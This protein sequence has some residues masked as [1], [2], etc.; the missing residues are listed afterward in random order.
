MIK[1]HLNKYYLY[2]TFLF[3]AQTFVSCN[4]KRDFIAEEIVAVE[5]QAAKTD[6]LMALTKELNIRGTTARNMADYKEALNLHFRALNLAEATKD[7]MGQIYALNNIGTDLRRTYS[8]IEASTYHYLAL[9][10]STGNSKY[11]KNRAMAMNGLGNIF[12]ALNK[13]EQARSYFQQALAI[14][15]A[16]NS[17]LGQAINYANLAETYH[18]SNDLDSSLYFYEES[19]KQNKIIDSDIGEAICKRAMGLIYYQKGNPD[20]ALSLLNEAF[21][22]MEN[23]K[24][25]FHKLE[26]QITLAETLINLN[27]TKDAEPHVLQILS[28]AKEVNTYD[29]QQKSYKL[30]A[31]LREKQQ[32]YRQAYEAKEMGLVYR[33]SVLAQN[34][35]VRIL[36]LENRYKGK[37]AAQKIQLLTTENILAEK[38]KTEMQRI[39]FLLILLLSIFIGFLY[40]RYNN[41]LKISK[42]LEKVNEIK[43]KFFGNISH[44][45]RTPL[46]LIKG[47]LEKWLERDLPNDLEKDAR[48]ML[49]NSERL[50]FLVDQ[51]LSLSKVDSDNFKINPQHADLSLALRGI[52]NYFLHIANE[53]SINYHIRI[54]S[55]GKEWIDLHIVEIIVTN[56]LSN[57]LKFTEENGTISLIGEKDKD[58][59]RVKVANS[60]KRIDSEE[61]PKIF[62]RFYTHGP[63]HY[64]STGIGLSLVKELCMLYNAKLTVEYNKKDEIEFTIVFPPLP[65]AEASNIE[66]VALENLSV[67]RFQVVRE[68]SVKGTLD[69]AVEQSSDLALTEKPVLLV[70]EDN[71][72]LRDYIVESFKDICDTL[73]AKNGE[74]GI[75]LAQEH[76]PD[77]VITDIMMPKIDGLQLCNTLKTNPTTNHIPIIILTAL[78]E[79]RDLIAGLENKADDYVTKPFGANILKQKVKNLIE[80]RNM[81]SQKYRTE[82]IIKPLDLLV[83]GG[84]DVFAQTLKDVIENEITNPDFGVDEFCNV[85]AMSRSQLYRKLKAT[86]DM[87]VS[88]FI[89]VHRIKLASELFKNKNLNVTDVCYASG[90]TDTSYFSKSFKEVFQMPPAEYRKKLHAE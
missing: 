1:L 42:E 72:D 39:F 81:M 78:N 7:T 51:L 35:E 57:A 88:E 31:K 79:E 87:S 76:I 58:N 48:V 49:R 8:N 27:R 70:V 45:F 16:S 38:N 80:V 59:Y 60:G 25:A 21:A 37:E 56:L 11:S 82:F 66:D 2:F 28:L 34:S 62:D 90:F 30:L 73:E 41:K 5:L 32:L 69:I 20:L 9:E 84:E 15:Q 29:Y 89:R 74:E 65:H 54:D 46:T 63:S 64:S 12:L 50:L 23:S 68:G 75:T 83:T 40:Y 33:D 22:L 44:E 3:V 61:L 86:V 71:D 14:E 26:V 43:S 52:A 17:N 85:A 36:E 53:R 47:P 19:L 4:L 55:S 24:D 77:I 18:I 10:L 6:S 67:D 13:T